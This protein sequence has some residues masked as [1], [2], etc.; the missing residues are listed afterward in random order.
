MANF[1]TYSIGMND[2]TPALKDVFHDILPDWSN[3]P[4]VRDYI[5][6]IMIIP[7]NFLP[8]KDKIPFLFDFWEYFIQIITFKAICIFFT[9][10]PSSNRYCHFS[11]NIKHCYHQSLSG[12]NSVVF[13]LFLLYSKYGLIN[14]CFFN[15][16][17]CI[18]YAMVVL[19]TRAHYTIDV[20]ESF[21]IVYLLVN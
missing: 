8:V 3:S 12:H 21:I 5:L 6:S 15:Y 13:L 20:I 1:R 4:D 7:I 19:A 17:P 16:I 10:L 18:L 11:N 14:N 2:D 9:Q